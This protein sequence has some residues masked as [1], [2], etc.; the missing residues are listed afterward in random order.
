MLFNRFY[1]PDVDVEH[2]RLARTLQLSTP[3][4]LPLRLRWLAILFARI[5]ASLVVSGGVHQATDALKA[6]LCG[7]QAVQLVSALLQRGPDHLKV[8][9]GEL[10]EWLERHGHDSLRQMVGRLALVSCPD[11]AAHERAN[12]ML[13][14]QSFEGA[15][16]GDPANDPSASGRKQG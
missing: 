11:A 12:Y 14:L 16:P 5:R 10:A 15:A 9:R 3:A 1:Q 6:V 13:I 4:E 7:A 2:V 8:V